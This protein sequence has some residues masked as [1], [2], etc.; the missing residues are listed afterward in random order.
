MVS[1]VP[2]THCPPIIH[3]GQ[4]AAHVS[5][6]NQTGPEPETVLAACVTPASIN[7]IIVQK[8]A[9]AH[10]LESLSRFARSCLSVK[11]A[12]NKPSACHYQLTWNSS[13]LLPSAL[14][15]WQFPL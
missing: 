4:L 5:A 11:V 8:D 15:V 7:L 2:P 3:G 12:C 9:L 13:R 14:F 1:G 6:S 10:P